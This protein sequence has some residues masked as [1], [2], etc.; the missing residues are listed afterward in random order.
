MFLKIIKL[1]LYVILL[2]IDTIPTVIDIIINLIDKKLE[3]ERC[4]VKNKNSSL[5]KSFPYM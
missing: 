3:K 2:L 5:V 1:A 4:E